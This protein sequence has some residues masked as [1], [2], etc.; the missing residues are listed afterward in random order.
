MNA[1]GTVYAVPELDGEAADPSY[2]RFIS[3]LGLTKTMI[4]PHYQ[5]CRNDV[6]DGLRLFEYLDELFAPDFIAQRP[7]ALARTAG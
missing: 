1:A 4:L 7:Q 5:A 2:R 6:I 3:G